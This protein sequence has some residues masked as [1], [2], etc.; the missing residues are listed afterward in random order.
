M[1]A[2]TLYFLG[3]TMFQT[4]S[5]I[6]KD[7]LKNIDKDKHNFNIRASYKQD[8]RNIVTALNEGTRS[9]NY[10]QIVLGNIELKSSYNFSHLFKK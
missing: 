3:G 7:I 4:A 9:P 1:D 2:N 5:N 8:G 10:S 6:L